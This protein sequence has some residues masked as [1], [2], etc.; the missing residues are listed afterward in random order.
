MRFVVE[1]MEENQYSMVPTEQ[2]KRC[3]IRQAEGRQ[4]RN[5]LKRQLRESVKNDGR[6][7]HVGFRKEPEEVDSD[8]VWT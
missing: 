2:A 7:K 8:G 4:L 6:Q 1:M 5:A 3:K